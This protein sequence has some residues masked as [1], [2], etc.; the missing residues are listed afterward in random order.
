MTTTLQII[1]SYSIGLLTG[2]LLMS[3]LAFKRWEALERNVRRNSYPL[4]KLL[5]EIEKKR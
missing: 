2:G 3:L 4:Y 1:L 5:K